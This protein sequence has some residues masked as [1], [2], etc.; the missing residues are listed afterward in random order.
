MLLR[1]VHPLAQAALD[2]FVA[3]SALLGNMLFFIDVPLR[4]M[5]IKKQVV[6]ALQQRVDLD[7]DH[8]RHQLEGLLF[9]HRAHADAR[10]W[11]AAPARSCRRRGLSEGVLEPLHE[12]LPRDAAVAVAVHF[13]QPGGRTKFAL[14]AQAEGF[15]LLRIE[16][17]IAI[18]VKLVKLV[19][20]LADPELALEHERGG[21][22]EEEEERERERERGAEGGNGGAR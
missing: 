1:C 6:R 2:E 10:A 18:L 15:E 16:S 19:Q 11:A 13:V 14:E 22:E 7:V 4:T 8:H 5:R 12:L 17:T 3:P 9:E 20:R 21:E